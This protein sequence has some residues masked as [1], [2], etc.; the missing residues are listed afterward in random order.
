VT[1][2]EISERTVVRREE[3][4]VSSEEG[5]WDSSFGEEDGEEVAVEGKR[6]RRESIEVRACDVIGPVVAGDRMRARKGDTIIESG[7]KA[8]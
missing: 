8:A 1:E 5:V 2:E 6:E 4:E 7:G 3:E